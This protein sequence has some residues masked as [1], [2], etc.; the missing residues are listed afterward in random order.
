MAPPSAVVDHG[1]AATTTCLSL[2]LCPMHSLTQPE[3]LYACTHIHGRYTNSG[4]RRVPAERFKESSVPRSPSPNGKRD[5]QER[6]QCP[7][8]SF[9][10]DLCFFSLFLQ[11]SV[12]CSCPNA[13]CGL[14]LRRSLQTPP[15]SSGNGL[16]GGGGS[17]LLSGGTIHGFLCSSSSSFSMLLANVQ[18]CLFL[19]YKGI[20]I[21]RVPNSRNSEPPFLS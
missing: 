15:R 10:G 14:R 1:R 6:R 2:P 19:V 5:D 13:A 12:I 18:N 17:F 9:L 4:R 16:I 7:G 11:G 8:A 20:W 3:S 21:P